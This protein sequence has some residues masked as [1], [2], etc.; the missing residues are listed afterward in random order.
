MSETKSGRIEK[1]IEKMIKQ[2]RLTIHD[3]RV[4][5]LY[6]T[7]SLMT[8]LYMLTIYNFKFSDFGYKLLNGN[9]ID[10]NLSL[11]YSNLT[12]IIIFIL[13]FSSIRGLFLRF[14]TLF[15]K[16]YF[17]P[18]LLLL[19]GSFIFIASSIQRNDPN[20]HYFKI[21]DKHSQASS[22]EN[23][24]PNVLLIIIDTM[25]S[26]V[27]GTYSPGK[28]ILTPNID[29][30]AAEGKVFQNH[31]SQCPWTTPSFG[32]FYTSKSPYEIFYRKEK[33]TSYANKSR[34][35]SW[36]ANKISDNEITIPLIFT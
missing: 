32:S 7:T 22:N 4:R 16:R 10:V 33:V 25:R 28:Q 21:Q 13:V 23:E 34:Y 1:T 11:I 30:I 3:M 14:S 17:I 2:D 31:Y 24:K 9:Q 27:I 29:R 6:V 20:Q 36:V 8:L 35:N 12:E 18:I 15:G 5:F 19:S 26:D